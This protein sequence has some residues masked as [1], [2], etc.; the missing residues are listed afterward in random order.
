[1]LPDRLTTA[2]LAVDRRL[3]FLARCFGMRAMAVWIRRDD[4]AE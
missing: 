4:V 2:M 1:L 3:E